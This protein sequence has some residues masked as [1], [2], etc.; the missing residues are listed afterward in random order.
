MAVGDGQV[1]FFGG[2]TDD[3]IGAAFA[4]TDCIERVHVF[5]SNSHHI[6]FLRLV[7]PDRERAHARLVIRY[8]TQL[9]FT[10]TATVRHQLREGVRQATRTYVVDK[11]NRVVIAQLPA[12]VDHFLTAAFHLWVF[13]LYRSKV[14]ISIR[15]ARRHRRRRATA[16]TN[17]H[18]RATQSD[19]ACADRDITLL[20]MVVTDIAVTTRY[21]NR[22][23][24]TTN[25]AVVLLFKGTEITTQR[26]TAK[27]VVKRRTTDGTLEHDVEG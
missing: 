15:L 1:F 19:Q 2:D 7:T 3:G 4:G 18:R 21:H 27:F 10:A 23:V 20:N 14:Q 12:A 13:T 25:F 6:A 16:Q 5:F 8:V 24:I 26:R 17:L 9:E 11:G 22:L